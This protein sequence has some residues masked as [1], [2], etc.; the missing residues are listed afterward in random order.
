M[1]SLAVVICCGGCGN[2]HPATY[3]VRGS[4]H[5]DDGRPVPV[6]NVEFRSDAGGYI[7]RGKIDQQGRFVLGTFAARD[8]A[9]AGSHHVIVVQSFDPI[10]W[11]KGK[12]SQP[13]ESP[14]GDDLDHEL[15]HHDHQPMFVS[16][17]FASYATSGLTANVRDQGSNVVDLAVGEPMSGE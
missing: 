2:R 13:R 1:A 14:G 7:A 15:Q 6:G 3:P 5:F 9:V 4:V 16:P 12:R 11:D 10:L 8:G 17:K